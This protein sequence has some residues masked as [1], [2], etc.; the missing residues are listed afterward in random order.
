MPSKIR[1]LDEK[2]VNRL[3]AGEVIEN[4]SSVIKELI[5]NAM[6]AGARKIRI[7]IESGGFQLICISDDGS[8]MSE[9]DALLALE[10][11]ATS[12]VRKISDL[13]HLKTMGFR[14]EALSSILA[15]SKLSFLTSDGLSTTQ[16]EG[17]GG[18]LLKVKKGARQ[19]GTTFE[20]RSLFYNTPARLSF[21]KS[22]SRSNADISKMVTQL[23]LSRPEVSF[24]LI[25]NG[26]EI[27]SLLP[28][29]LFGRAGA[30][31]GK[32]FTQNAHLIELQEEGLKLKGLLG[33]ASFLRSN[34]SG[35]YFYLNQR[36]IQSLPLTYGVEEGYGT[37][38]STRNYP[39]FLLQLTLDGTK[40]DV[41]VHPQKKEVRFKEESRLREA[42]RRAVANTFVAKSTHPLLKLPETLFEPTTFQ[43]S[44][45]EAPFQKTGSF[46]PA[47]FQE[48]DYF[49]MG[50]FRHFLILK[51]EEALILVD[52]KKAS[53][54]LFKS[55]SEVINLKAGLLLPLTFDFS[56]SEAEALSLHLEE[57]D[58]IGISVKMF[59]ERTF[60]VEAL[61]PSI[62]EES[63]K[64]LLDSFLTLKDREK[65]FK[66]GLSLRKR[67]YSPAEA[68][69]IYEEM[70]KLQ[71]KLEGIK[72]L[73]EKDLEKFISSP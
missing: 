51:E 56:P 33:S 42:L 22:V 71:G 38:L 15:V 67:A 18:R 61:A 47:L 2:T 7:E 28:D 21:Q 3:A 14:G 52:L 45:I 44:L 48:P 62:E 59:G 54:Q 40:M 64:T 35:Q 9:D 50:L 66:K 41:N 13:D 20:V 55:R 57:L 68:K 16:V 43:E 4:P 10:R 29:D 31:L 46:E 26:K 23:A 32:E 36:P 6:D 11:H 37:R 49:I 30:L 39:L 73:E 58:Q 34:R 69:K 65:V 72:I 5:D 17:A 12:K 63:V 19:R 53:L 60:I 1:V 27:F 24:S 70:R 25:S 8:G